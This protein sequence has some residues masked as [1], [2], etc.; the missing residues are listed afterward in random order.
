[1]VLN[2]SLFALV[3]LIYSA[4]CIHRRICTI[5]TMKRDMARQFSRHFRMVDESA[6][7]QYKEMGGDSFRLGREAL[8]SDLLNEYRLNEMLEREDQQK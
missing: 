6:L 2:L 1:M 4:L 7:L 8:L 3:L 5:R